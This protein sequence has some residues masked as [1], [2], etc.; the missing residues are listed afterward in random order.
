MKIEDINDMLVS[1]MNRAR[2]AERK[3]AYEGCK[4]RGLRPPRHGLPRSLHHCLGDQTACTCSGAQA[5][6][7]GGCGAV[8]GGIS[9]KYL[10]ISRYIT[11]IDNEMFSST[12]K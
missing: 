1:D 3:R 11:F 9:R 4:P 12:L 6:E 8:N 5:Q 7:A 2:R 10:L